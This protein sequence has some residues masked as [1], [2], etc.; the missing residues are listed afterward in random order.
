MSAPPGGGGGLSFILRHADAPPRGASGG[1]ARAGEIADAGFLQPLCQGGFL[2]PLTRVSPP[3]LRAPNSA[4]SQGSRSP[5]P[6]RRRLGTTR[7]D[8]VRGA[9]R[10]VG[11]KLPEQLQALRLFDPRTLTFPIH[12]TDARTIQPTISPSFEVGKCWFLAPASIRGGLRAIIPDISRLY[13][14]SLLLQLD[15][16]WF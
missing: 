1:C 9:R 16:A 14:Q 7:G 2:S 3:R 15:C 5:W 6:R 12:G 4:S 8:P 10:E 13:W 11:R